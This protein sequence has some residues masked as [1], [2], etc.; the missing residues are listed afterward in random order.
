M[1][2]K[3]H[4]KALNKV[5]LGVIYALV[6]ITIAVMIGIIL[7][8]VMRGLFKGGN[9]LKGFNITKEY[10][11][12]PTSDGGKTGGI[13]AIVGNT[14]ILVLMSGLI[15]GVIGISAAIYLCFYARESKFT[16]LIR[17][18]IEVLAGIPSI[19]FGLFGLLI[20]VG[21]CKFGYSLLSGILTL[22]IMIL[23]TIISTSENAIQGVDKSLFEASI[24]LGGTRLESIIKVVLKEAK[25]GIVSG[26]ILSLGRA[27]GETAALVY[28]VGSSYRLAHSLLSS[29]RPL[30]MHIYLG[31]NEGQS[32]DKAFAG[33]LVLLILCTLMIVISS[34]I[35]KHFGKGTK[36]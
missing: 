15:S 19:I 26:M 34:L 7:Y 10:L 22:S 17:S 32:L 31:I 14:V 1:I 33:S 20:F 3:K 6:G 24:G 5:F 4:N 27:L 25:H 35:L 13:I 9:P 8:I 16:S 29:A 23:P 2:D 28:T 12:T 11:F 18:A 21:L 30:A 36:K